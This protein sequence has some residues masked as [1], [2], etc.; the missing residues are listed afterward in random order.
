VQRAKELADALNR[1]LEE[2]GAPSNVRERATIL[3]KMFDIPK[4]LAWSLLEGHLLPEDSL[5]QKI[6]EEFEL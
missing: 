1:N 5:L 2:L 6:A 3:S 4:Q